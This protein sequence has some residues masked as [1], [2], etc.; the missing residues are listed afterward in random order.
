L[1]QITK[2]LSRLPGRRVILAV[3]NG[4]DKGSD[5]HTWN[6]VRTLAQVSG[7]TIFGV[8]YLQSGSPPPSQGYEN[9]FSDLCQLSGGVVIDTNEIV[10]S[11]SLRRFTRILRERYIVE[12]P[13]P[14][15][16]T[17]GQENMRVRID[18]SGNDFVRA[19]GKAVPLP[20]AAVMA[21]PTTVPSDP[22]LTPE[23][24]RRKILPAPQ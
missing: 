21:D 13:R 19:S 4:K 17:A 3:A 5:H 22:S 11:R 7:V 23:V 6:E 12:F 24:G 1:G 10:V 9:A 16:A 2:N 8:S 14:A 15:N 18:K 20:N